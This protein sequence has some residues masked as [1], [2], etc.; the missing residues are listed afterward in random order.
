MQLE[1][2][3]YID[4]MQEWM[5]EVRNFINQENPK[6]S[7]IAETYINEAI[8]GRQLIADNLN[9]LNLESKLLEVGAGSMLLSTQLVREGRNVTALEPVGVGFSHFNQL[10]KLVLDLASIHNIKPVIININ[11]ENLNEVSAYDFAF[12]IN[13]MEHVQSVDG[14]IKQVVN[15]LR[16]NACYRFICPNYF[17]PYEPHFNIPI[18][19]NKKITEKILRN[20]IY[21]NKSMPDAKGVWDSLNWISVSQ[22]RR[23]TESLT[24]L[25]VTFNKEIIS[26]TIN[27]LVSDNQFSLRRSAL[28]IGAGKVMLSLK[29]DRMFEL[30]P[31]NILPVIDC[32]IVKN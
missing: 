4:Y 15:S 19:L 16:V 6:L 31:V 3:M 24:N 14:V 23:I 12:S 8:Y 1:N 10:Q 17:F 25:S 11:A 21:N 20:K 22:I 27:R 29:F 2:D 26:I 28:I 13:V 9:Q 5:S 30:M 18:L 32:T 7:F